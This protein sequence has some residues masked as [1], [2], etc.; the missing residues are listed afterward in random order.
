MYLDVCTALLFIINYLTF[1]GYFI[2][3]FTF[4]FSISINTQSINQSIN[5]PTNQHLP[6][7]KSINRKTKPHTTRTPTKNTTQ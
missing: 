7:Q 5:Q 3:R 6:D 2:M 4:C 1:F